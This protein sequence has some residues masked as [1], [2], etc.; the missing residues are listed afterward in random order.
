MLVVMASIIIQEHFEDDD[1]EDRNHRTS[2]QILRGLGQE[3]RKSGCVTKKLVSFRRD[4]LLLAAKDIPSEDQTSKLKKFRFPSSLRPEDFFKAASGPCAC[5]EFSMVVQC[6]C[7][8]GVSFC[9]DQCWLPR[10]KFFR[11]SYLRPLVLARSQNQNQP[12]VRHEIRFKSR[13]TQNFPWRS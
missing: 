11:R 2:G 13:M 8:L 7:H 3:G 10:H 9:P 1:D 6:V 4:A 12:S 5:C